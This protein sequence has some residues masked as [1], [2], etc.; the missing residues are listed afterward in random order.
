[1]NNIYSIPYN[2][3]ANEI[4]EKTFQIISLRPMTLPSK[5]RKIRKYTNLY[6][7]IRKCERIANTKEWIK[8]SDCARG[9]EIL[10]S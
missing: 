7:A 6:I 1:M 9:F 4:R 5:Y 2:V 10:F 3:L 8:F